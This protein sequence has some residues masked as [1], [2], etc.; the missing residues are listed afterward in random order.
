DARMRNLG[1]RWLL[2]I[3]RHAGS[4]GIFVVVA[5]G[6]QLL[7]LLADEEVDEA[8]CIR[9]VLRGRENGGAGYVDDRSGV[10]AREVIEIRV[11]PVSPYLASQ[12]VPVVLVDHANRYVAGVDRRDHRLIILVDDGILLQRVD[13]VG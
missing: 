4:H 2:R 1:E 9:A 8:L 10:P 5:A 7:A 12:P 6:D 13:T 11:D 3:V